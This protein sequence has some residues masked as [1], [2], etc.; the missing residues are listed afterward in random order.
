MDLSPNTIVRWQL[1]WVEVR[2]WITR[3][4]PIH[5][6]GNETLW[7]KVDILSLLVFSLYVM[8]KEMSQ[9]TKDSQTWMNNLL[10]TLPA[11]NAIRMLCAKC[12]VQVWSWG[13]GIQ[14]ECG[15]GGDLSWSVLLTAFYLVPRHKTRPQTKT[16]TRAPS[17]QQP[18]FTFICDIIKSD[19]AGA[20][21][22]C[23]A[24]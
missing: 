15:N 22:P 5:I 24:V 7:K 1:H 16:R 13:R 10:Q 20:W 19:R 8:G 23:N 3:V 4:N 14:G 18:A 21:H 2:G 17:N 6:C 9:V 11:A 12:A